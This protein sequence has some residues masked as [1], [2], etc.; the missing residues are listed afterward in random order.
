MGRAAELGPLDA[1][2]PHEGEIVSMISALDVARSI[3]D[4]A[5]TAMEFAFRGGA[6]A[7]QTTGLSRSDTLTAMLDFSAKFMQP[8]LSQLDPKMIHWSSTLLSVASAYAKR[9]LEMRTIPTSVLA[10]QIPKA[11]VDNYPTHGFVI[12][13]AEAEGLGLPVK[14]IDDYDLCK[15]VC[16]LHRTYE[17]GDV[18]LVS[19]TSLEALKGEGGDGGND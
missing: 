15:E 16:A 18:N 1:Q 8:V 13:I 12:G 4:L 5:K 3:D 11:L 6:S 2:I 19:L 14:S 9:L 7:L 10:S 17:D